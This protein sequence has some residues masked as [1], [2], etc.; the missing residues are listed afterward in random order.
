MSGSFAFQYEE[1]LR[2]KDGKIAA[3]EARNAEKLKVL[4]T[5][6]RI[7]DAENWSPEETMNHIFESK[8]IIEA[9]TK[10]TKGE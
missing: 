3:L 5:V 2:D 9:E 4:K 7:S 1:L 6:I 8:R 10:I